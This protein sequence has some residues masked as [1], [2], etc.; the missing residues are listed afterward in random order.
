MDTE[1]IRC[2]YCN[3][4]NNLLW[5]T[6]NGFTAV[7]CI[8]CGLIYV[9]PRPSADLISEAVKTGVHRE[10]MQGR[11][12]IARRV[13]SHVKLYKK[14]IKN[15]YRDVWQRAEPISWLDVG[16]GYGEFIEAISSL[17]PKGSKVVGLEPMSPK[18]AAARNRGLN[19]REAYLSEVKEKYQF[20]SLI[21]VF[22]HIPDFRTFLNDI[23][24]V[25]VSDGEI[26]IETGN[27]ADL[28]SR[29]EVPSEL[30]LPDHLVFAGEQH[31][32][33]FL[34]NAGFQVISVNRRRKDGLLTF[35]KNIVKKLLGRTVTIRLPYTSNYR[36]LIVRAKLN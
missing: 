33:G 34:Q 18:A 32:T 1:N 14:L 19:I 35:A 5:A 25:L 4:D 12:V 26:L 6:E 28:T 13:A 20:V 10:A 23:K 29:Q 27:A 36:T 15:V 3:E 17:A 30:A 31:I 8:E 7:K 22:S 24:G 2:L 21:N 11:T 16:A 9:N